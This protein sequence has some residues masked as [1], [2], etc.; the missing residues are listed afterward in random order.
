MIQQIQR[1]HPITA[2]TVS[3]YNISVDSS[4]PLD[5]EFKDKLTTSTYK[6]IITKLLLTTTSKS[7]KV[8]LDQVQLNLLL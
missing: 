1:F 6:I 3:I 4:F 8:F 7:N 2:L 5:N